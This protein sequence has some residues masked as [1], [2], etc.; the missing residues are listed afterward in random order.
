M[1]LNEAFLRASSTFLSSTFLSGERCVASR[2]TAAKET[3]AAS[4]RHKTIEQIA[5]LMERGCSKNKLFVST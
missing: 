2:K 3:I 4:K 1:A 5:V